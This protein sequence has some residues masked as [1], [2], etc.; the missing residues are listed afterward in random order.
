MNYNHKP[1]SNDYRNN[2]K[3][4]EEVVGEMKSYAST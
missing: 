2:R 4:L 3:K 1:S